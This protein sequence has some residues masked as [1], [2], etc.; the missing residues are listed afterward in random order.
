MRSVRGCEPM[1]DQSLAAIARSLAAALIAEPDPKLLAEV[2]AM[3]RRREQKQVTA[4]EA[5]LCS[6]YRDEI[7]ETLKV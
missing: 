7:I 1:S 5:E 6:A 4:L 3:R 2:E